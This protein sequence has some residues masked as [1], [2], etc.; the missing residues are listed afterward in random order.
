MICSDVALILS[1]LVVFPISNAKLDNINTIDAQTLLLFSL[2]F[3][4]I[5]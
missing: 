3:L 1:H 2:S 4:A 5:I